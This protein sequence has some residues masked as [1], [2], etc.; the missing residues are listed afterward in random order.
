MTILRL[1]L[2]GGQTTI[3]NQRPE[4]T[5]IMLDAQTMFTFDAA[6]RLHGAFVQGSTF[7]RSLANAILEKRP[8]PPA[9]LSSR[10]RRFLTPA[11]VQAL[12]QRAYDTAAEVLAHIQDQGDASAGQAPAAIL[13]ALA[14]VASCNYDK[15]EDERE[16]YERLYKPVTILPPD[17]YLAL[18]LQATEGCAY[19]ACTFCGF[20][21]DR[22]FHVKTLAEFRAHMDA[23]RAFFG[24]AL[25]L[26]RSIFLGDANA[27]MIPQAALLP[28]L[29]AV[30]TEFVIAPPGLTGSALRAW[31]EAHP[32]HLQ[33]IYSFVDAFSTRRKTVEDWR[34]LAARG[35]R[36]AYI[37]LE[38]GDPTL[39]RF[40]GKPNTPA[41][42]QTLIA[43]LK[44]AG[45]AVGI[46]VLVGAGGQ[47]YQ[48]AHITATTRLI[49][50]LPL[51][52]H[53][54]IY[55]SELMD[56]PTAT[57]EAQ[58]TTAGLRL[59]AA[60]EIEEQSRR[61]RAGLRFWRQ[62]GAPKVSLYDIREF[63]Y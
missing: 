13:A 33:G 12:E 56:Y 51:D 45:V 28:L 16:V 6:G 18:Y 46:I 5:T 15:L 63:I 42:A 44:E 52:A 38:T 41:E 54:L 53:D 9:G 58:A 35:L 55:F 50:A 1:P 8:G 31:K 23:V 47:T 24:E 30:N 48:E 62:P 10:Q 59:L 43:H 19:D 11:E 14:R 36:R 4:S 7:R 29:D 22:R 17:Q 26:R 40:L 61:L 20:Y 37:G 39:L 49:N 60:S 32:Q 25:T 27:L 57:Y 34:A 2:P 21:R 3:I